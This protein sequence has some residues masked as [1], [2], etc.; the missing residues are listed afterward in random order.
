MSQEEKCIFRELEERKQPFHYCME[1][2]CSMEKIEIISEI[3]HKEMRQTC[4]VFDK[5]S[6][7]SV[8]NQLRGSITV[9]AIKDF[10]K[11]ADLSGV[12]AIV[13]YDAE[14]I[15]SNY[16]KCRKYL[17]EM[18]SI[19]EAYRGCII[20]FSRI[21]INLKNMI[22]FTGNYNVCERR[23]RSAGAALYGLIDRKSDVSSFSELDELEE[24]VS[25]E[26]KLGREVLVV[27]NGNSK[28]QAVVS[29]FKHPTKSKLFLVKST[30]F[31]K[32]TTESFSNVETLIVDFF[33]VFS[34]ARILMHPALRRKKLHLYIFI[35]KRKMKL[36][37]QTYAEVMKRTALFLDDRVEY[38]N[39]Y[40]KKSIDEL[41]ITYIKPIKRRLRANLNVWTIMFHMY[42][43][44]TGYSVT[45]DMYISSVCE[46]LGIEKQV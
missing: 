3:E 1:E 46:V 40:Y 22:M 44:K 33:D 41:D 21:R 28:M 19:F 37:N 42:L 6:V 30:D 13:V 16:A 12:D 18:Q 38:E 36:A 8:K 24:L 29:R 20:W 2:I 26:F 32:W 23:S 43:Q 31:C 7:N 14:T 39:Q 9:V 10:V 34:I 25:S 35:D 45:S 11:S 4:L 5:E 17:L 15:V 27:T